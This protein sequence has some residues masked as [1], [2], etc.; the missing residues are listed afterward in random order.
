MQVGQHDG[1]ETDVSNVG[2]LSVTKVELSV[3]VRIGH[4]RP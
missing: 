1:E 4:L 3:Y 2:L